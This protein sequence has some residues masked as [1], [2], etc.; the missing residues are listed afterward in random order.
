MICG[1]G[2]HGFIFDYLGT[3]PLG[4]DF[5]Y[6]YVVKGEVICVG[7]LCGKNKEQTKVSYSY[8]PAAFSFSTFSR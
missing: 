7:N 6:R 4:P 3:T 1:S 2:W 8:N 5:E